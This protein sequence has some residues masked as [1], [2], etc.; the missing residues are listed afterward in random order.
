MRRRLLAAA[1]ECLREKGYAATTVTEVQERAGVARGTLLHHFPAKAELMVAATEHLAL[2]RI[3]RLRTEAAR[4]PAGA[5]RLPAVVDLAWAD[6]ASPWFFTA[7]ELW[8]AART[9][10]ALRS[11]LLPVQERLFRALHVG[12]FSVLDDA[13]LGADPRAHTLVELTIDA[14]TGI[15]MTTMLSDRGPQPE[16]LLARWKRALEVL[17][18]SR[19]A[20]DWL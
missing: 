4:I 14:L 11:T 16:L 19:S 3:E 2:E 1:V 18:G 20:A 5:D 7:L 12:L 9:D 6:L 10:A 15:A 17:I 8:V 13:A